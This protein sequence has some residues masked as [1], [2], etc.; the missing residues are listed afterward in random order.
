MNQSKSSN[1]LRDVMNQSQNYNYFNNNYNMNNKNSSNA[2]NFKPP[3]KIQNSGKKMFYKSGY[4]SMNNSN[5][6]NSN[7]STGYNFNNRQ[8]NGFPKQNSKG[9][10]GALFFNLN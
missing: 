10:G 1:N 2:V 7:S 4:N 3:F 5:N 9:G 8:Q 6:F